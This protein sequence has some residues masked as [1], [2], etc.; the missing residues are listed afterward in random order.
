M[1]ENSTPLQKPRYDWL[2]AIKAVAMAFV[3][4]VHLG[5]NGFTTFVMYTSFLKLPLFFAASGFVFNPKKQMSVKEFLITRSKRI[6]VPYLCLS[7]ILC[8]FDLFTYQGTF[9]E[10]IKYSLDL[11]C[12]GKIMWFFPTL[13]LC[14]FLMFIIFKITKSNDAT[15][16]ISAVISLVLGY[17]CIT[18]KHI[19]MAVNAVFVAYPMCVFGYYLKS[20]LALVKKNYLIIIATISMIVFLALPALYKYHTGKFNYINLFSSLYCSY[21]YDMLVVYSG[22]LTFFIFFSFMKFPKFVVKFGQNTIFYYAFHIPACKLIM[23]LL[24]T[25]VSPKFDTKLLGN[26]HKGILIY[27]A[28]TLFTLI[29]LAPIC[30]LVNKYIPFIVGSKKR[31]AK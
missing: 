19:F 3:I 6:L 28:V 29:V 11:I 16:I 21:F 18:G 5:L 20:F 25:F 27:S 22:V 31:K 14:N 1:G 15:V 12:M 8:I 2:D 7:V 10:W 13:F 26:T 30:T 9:T 4:F 17:F 24:S 23:F